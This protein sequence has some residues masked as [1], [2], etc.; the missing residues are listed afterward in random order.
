MVRLVFRPY[1]Q[2][3]R[4]ICR[5]VSLREA[6]ASEAGD[7]PGGWGALARYRGS[8]RWFLQFPAFPTT[9]AVSQ[10]STALHREFREPGFSNLSAQFSRSWSSQIRS[11][12]TAA[13]ALARGRAPLRPPR[14]RRCADTSHL[15]E[16]LHRFGVC[17][18]K[19]LNVF[20]SCSVAPQVRMMSCQHLAV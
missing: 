9:S 5:S 14:P 7:R 8:F 20:V 11:G 19:A 12:R 18:R 3:W 15:H 17:R 2:L 4:T 1:A 16:A 13:K 6:A 10:V